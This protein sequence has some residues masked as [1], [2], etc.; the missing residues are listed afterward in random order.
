[1]LLKLYIELCNKD[2]N[3]LKDF[4]VY[5]HHVT[6]SE[7][8]NDLGRKIIDEMCVSAAAAIKL[9]C[10]REYGFSDDGEPARATVLAELDSNDLIG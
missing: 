4:V 7:P 2:I 6:I 1:M 5:M 3:T 8:Q 9:Q 10:G